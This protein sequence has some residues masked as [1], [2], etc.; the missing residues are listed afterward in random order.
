MPTETSI[1]PDL[2]PAEESALA[3]ALRE[4]VT[5][6]V[7]H[8]GAKTCRVR[9]ETAGE[10]VRLEVADDG[11]GGLAPL[12]T[13]G[14]GLTGMRERLGALGGKV[15][16]ESAGPEGGTRLVMTLPYTAGRPKAAGSG[17]APPGT[18]FGLEQA[19]AGE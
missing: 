12:A 19:F 10:T 4:A 2:T 13:E 16:R 18:T 5:N 11:R 6:V 14:S 1:P 7:R 15:E 17:H 8:A 3:F 9:I